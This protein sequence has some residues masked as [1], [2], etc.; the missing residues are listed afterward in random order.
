[1]TTYISNFDLA[2]HYNE[3]ETEHY[4]LNILKIV[5]LLLITSVSIYFYMEPDKNSIIHSK[6]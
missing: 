1:V 6:L 4:R 5:L 2:S 3:E